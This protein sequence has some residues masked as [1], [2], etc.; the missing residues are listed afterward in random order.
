MCFTARGKRADEP[1]AFREL[2]SGHSP[3]ET[4]QLKVHMLDPKAKQ[5]DDPG[6]YKGFNMMMSVTFTAVLPALQ[7][8]LSKAR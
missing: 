8:S 5:C 3:V 1:R 6:S 2:D 4:A 7:L